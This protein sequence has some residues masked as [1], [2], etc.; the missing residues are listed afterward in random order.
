MEID[1]KIARYGNSLTVRLPVGVA[2]EL[3]VRDG[4]RVVLRSVDGGVLIE[5]PKRSRLAAMLATVERPE[6]EIETGPSLGRE[7]IE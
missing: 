6:S 3:G 7:G 5:R 2:R 1:S 4:D